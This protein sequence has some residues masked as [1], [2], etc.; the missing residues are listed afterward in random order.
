MSLRLDRS[1]ERSEKRFEESFHIFGGQLE[2]TSDLLQKFNE[3]IDSAPSRAD[4]DLA[5]R[6]ETYGIRDTGTL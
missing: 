2:D 4:L 6:N 1:N 3:W 5:S